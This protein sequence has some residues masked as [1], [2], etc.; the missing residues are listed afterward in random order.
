MNYYK[1]RP[2][3][4]VTAFES[5]GISSADMHATMNLIATGRIPDGCE[6]A[7]LIGLTGKDVR[8]KSEDLIFEVVDERTKAAGL[9]SV[10]RGWHYTCHNDNQR[11][12]WAVGYCAEH[13]PHATKREAEE[14]YRKHELDKTL[15]FLPDVPLRGGTTLQEC[16]ECEAITTGFAS[17]GHGI[18]QFIPLCETHRTR[19]MVEKHWK[20]S[21]DSFGSY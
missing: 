1:A 20:F 9:P 17:I 18:P 14:C 8:G 7:K 3:L 6:I 15:R 5:K 4:N 16:A 2:L 11:R 12:T 13:D 19:P 21:P 10:I